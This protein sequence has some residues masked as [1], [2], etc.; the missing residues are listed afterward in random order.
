MKKQKIKLILEEIERVTSLAI[1]NNKDKGHD[2]M[3]LV[4]LA[5][6]VLHDKCLKFEHKSIKDNVMQD[7]V[8][9]M[10][11]KIDKGMH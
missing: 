9:F 10:A 7:A 2:A 4:V 3:D 1:E 5:M 8:M 11:T 6:G